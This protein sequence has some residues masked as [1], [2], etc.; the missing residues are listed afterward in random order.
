LRHGLK[1]LIDS[2]AEGVIDKDHF[3]A[4]TNA[5]IAEIDKKMGA[6]AAAVPRF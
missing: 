5:R 1:R 4:R 3:P 6:Q 2:L